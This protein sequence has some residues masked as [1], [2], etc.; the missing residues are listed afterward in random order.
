MGRS[1]YE[2][3]R[4]NSPNEDPVAGIEDP[5][6]LRMGLLNARRAPRSERPSQ[7]VVLSLLLDQR[8]AVYALA[9]LPEEGGV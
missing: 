7:A 1:N 6:N 3:D 9:V 4:S 2:S 8:G 5:A